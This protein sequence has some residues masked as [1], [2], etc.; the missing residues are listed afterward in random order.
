[1]FKNTGDNKWT[2]SIFEAGTVV[3]LVC[4]SNFVA[5]MP[6]KGKEEVKIVVV[7]DGKVFGTMCEI[8]LICSL[9]ESW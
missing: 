6:K 3:R 8:Q 7:G 1:L 5:A 9:R 4:A 2:R